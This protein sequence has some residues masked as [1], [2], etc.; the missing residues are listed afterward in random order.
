[1]TWPAPAKASER[2]S[3]AKMNKA[4]KTCAKRPSESL[5]SLDFGSE[6]IEHDCA[7]TTCCLL[8][9]PVLVEHVV[10]CHQPGASLGSVLGV[11]RCRMLKQLGPGS[12]DHHW[13]MKLT[14]HLSQPS[15]LRE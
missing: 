7:I 3:W 12:E 5:E 6:Q 11:F 8:T 14:N 10:S 2:T 1:M 4:L 15:H 13:N 9:V